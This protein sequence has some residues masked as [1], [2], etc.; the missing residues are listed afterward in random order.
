MQLLGI[1]ARGTVA[2]VLAVLGW[3][4]TINNYSVGLQDA[5]TRH[6]MVNLGVKQHEVDNGWKLPQ[7]PTKAI[8]S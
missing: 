6:Q 1:F 4:V 2:R 7:F 5:F 3:S 8:L